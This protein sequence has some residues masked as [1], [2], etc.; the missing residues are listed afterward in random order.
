MTRTTLL[1]AV[2]TLF[3]WAA[4]LLLHAL[5]PAH[6]GE[7]LELW[8]LLQVPLRGDSPAAVTHRPRG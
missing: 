3:V 1:Q 6:L 4:N 2:R 5:G 8:S 7:P